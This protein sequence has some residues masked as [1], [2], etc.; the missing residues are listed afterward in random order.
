M[1]E[2]RDVIIPEIKIAQRGSRDWFG[3]RY[4]W[5]IIENQSSAPNNHNGEENKNQAEET[6]YSQGEENKQNDAEEIIGM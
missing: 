3:R 5:E 2:G 1:N 4:S 6:N